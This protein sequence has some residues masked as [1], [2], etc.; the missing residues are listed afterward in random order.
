MG[1]TDFDRKYDLHEMVRGDAIF[2]A[3]GVT[4]GALLD[5]VPLE[6]GFVHTH[7]LVMNSVAPRT[8]RDSP[9]DAGRCSDAM[10]AIGRTADGHG[11]GFLG[12]LGAIRSTGRR[13]ARAPGRRRRWSARHQLQTLGLSEPLA[14]APGRARHRRGR[15]RR[16]S[17]TRR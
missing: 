4:K 1:I 5:G 9:H 11:D 14:R 12:R 16:P 8:V 2:A 13:L 15:R 10:D 6:G 3:T 7:T 17:S